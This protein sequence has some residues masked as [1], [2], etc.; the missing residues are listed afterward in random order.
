MMIG[1]ARR[2]Q[3]QFNARGLVLAMD[4]KVSLS[5]SFYLSTSLSV[6]VWRATVLPVCLACLSL[7]CRKTSIRHQSRRDDDDDDTRGAGAAAN[8]IKYAQSTCIRRVS[9]ALRVWRRR[10]I[11]TEAG[12]RKMRARFAAILFELLLVLERHGC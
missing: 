3:S 4:V 6:S 7:C 9:A 11:C 8:N 10:R 12:T 1:A 5:L 2:H